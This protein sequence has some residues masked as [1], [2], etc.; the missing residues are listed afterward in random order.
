MAPKACKVKTAATSS[1]STVAA[2]TPASTWTQPPVL[3]STPATI[4]PFVPPAIPVKKY[5]F[6]QRATAPSTPEVSL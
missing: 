5:G 1:H 6:L 3:P 2:A 4:S